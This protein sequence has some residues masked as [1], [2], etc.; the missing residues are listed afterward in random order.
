MAADLVAG[1]LLEVLD[2]H[3]GFL[4]DV[5]RMQAHE[6]RQRPGRLLALDIGIVLG[7]LDQL[8]VGLVADVAL[9]H[10]LYEPFLDGLPHGVAVEGLAITAEDRQ[11]LVFGRGGEGEKA[12]VGLTT[13]LGHGAKQP[14]QLCFAFFLRRFP[15]LADQLC[16]TQHAFEFGGRLTRLGAVCLVDDHRILARRQMAAALTALLGQFHQLPG[17]EGEFLQGGDDDR[18]ARFQ[19]L[20]QLARILVDLLHYALTVVELVDSVLQ[21]A[22]EHH[23]VG[24]HHHAV[25]DALVPLVV[26]GGEPM[27]QPADSVALA[28]ARRVFN[29]IVMADA[30]AARCRHHLPYR[31]QLV[32]AGEDHLLLAH[33]LAFVA[34]FLVNV[35]VEEARQQIQ[36]AFAAEHLFPKIGGLVISA[37]LVRR[38][39]CA[40]V[41]ALVEGQKMGAGPG[42]ARGHVHLFGV[43][44]KMHQGALGK[45][46]DLF[47]RVAAVTV[48]VDGIGR[49]LAGERI[50]QLQGHHRNAVG[51]QH[52][53]QRI[54]VLVT[55]V[56]LSGDAQAVGAVTRLQFRVEAMGR[57]KESNAQGL[58]EA[59]E[60][61]AQGGQSTV[62]VQPFGKRRKDPFPGLRPMQRFE[63][64]PGVALGFADK[65]QRFVAKDGPLGI[66]SA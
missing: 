14:L 37:L 6:A 2:H 35:Q 12:H 58:A 49:C 48:L 60:A 20:G 4:A 52:H 50:F 31:L 22:V 40:A 47:A 23:P 15:R 1:M 44:G 10:I 17:D 54:L 38:I 53:I 61:M 64:L 13:A 25:E 51:R 41:P 63:F 18:H 32:V 24:N 7:F 33:L 29:Q 27:R 65:S 19:R 28:A 39:T 62:G 30:L 42:Q 26:Q 45:K 36:Q 9:Q 16:S 3:L 21:L 43:H 5:V 46:E 34:D 57:S 8:V 55:K 59:F 66:E 11:G 56:K